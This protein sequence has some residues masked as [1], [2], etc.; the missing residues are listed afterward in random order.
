MPKD[1][2]GSTKTKAKKK[3]K[4][5][6]T[7]TKVVSVQ[8]AK[9]LA[10]KTSDKTSKRRKSLSTSANEQGSRDSEVDEDLEVGDLVS[11]GEEL[12]VVDQVNEERKESEEERGDTSQAQKEVSP[13]VLAEALLKVWQEQDFWKK[14][15]K[16]SVPPEEKAE[17]PEGLG[18]SQFT[19]GATTVQTV[20]G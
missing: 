9:A 18:D 7:T 14:L 2:Q 4:S 8:K 17:V 10:K 20:P 3:S 6:G 16:V 13:Y 12:G 1:T 5:K 11:T 15:A 19:L